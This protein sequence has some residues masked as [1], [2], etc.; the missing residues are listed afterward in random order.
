VSAGSS[1]RIRREFSDRD[2]DQF[3]EGAFDSIARLFKTSLAALER[4]NLHIQTRFKRIDAEHFSA[5]VYVQGDVRSY[6]RVWL[7]GR[8]SF[9]GGIGYSSNDTGDDHSF[10]ESLSVGDDGYTLFLKPLGMASY[11]SH[12]PM[13]VDEAAR[14]L[15]SLFMKPLR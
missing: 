9:T 7:G 2:K 1:L 3:L 5:V 14:Y 10:N 15:W 13:S 6:C 8:T 12:D 4:E 11:G